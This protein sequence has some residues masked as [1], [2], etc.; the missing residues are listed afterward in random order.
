MSNIEQTLEN[1]LDRVDQL[2]VVPKEGLYFGDRVRVTTLDATYSI[3]VL[4]D[5]LY[6]VSG[7]WFDHHNLSP[8]KTTINGCTWGGSAIK[9]DIVAALGLRLEFGNRLLSS[10]IQQVEIL[11][12]E[13]DQVH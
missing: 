12:F 1:I 7:G 5:D 13:E 4:T 6:A 10:P 3:H 11:R 2:E 8:F 9:V